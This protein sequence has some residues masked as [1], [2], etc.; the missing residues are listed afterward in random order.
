MLCLHAMFRDHDEL[1]PGTDSVAMASFLDSLRSIMI[2]FNAT[3][4]VV[5]LFVPELNWALTTGVPP[6]GT[7]F[8]YWSFTYV[9]VAEQARTLDDV[10][11]TC[12]TLPGYPLPSCDILTMYP[13]EFFSR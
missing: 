11:S 4:S 12:F 6:D 5:V 10:L 2:S 8:P 1:G 7:K 9:M 13:R 3:Y